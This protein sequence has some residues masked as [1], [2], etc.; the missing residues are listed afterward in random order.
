MQVMYRHIS[1]QPLPPSQL[2][3]HL[4]TAIDA[5]ILTALAKQ[6]A[7]RY[8]SVIDFARAFQQAL[9]DEAMMP[10]VEKET[11]LPPTI[12]A[13]QPSFMPSSF[14]AEIAPITP[15]RTTNP[16]Q[17]AFSAISMVPPPPPAY[18]PPNPAAR[19]NMQKTPWGRVAASVAAVCL[20]I[21]AGVLLYSGYQGHAQQLHAHMTATALAHVTA[22]AHAQATISVNITATVIAGNHY[23]A[24]LP[25][26]G[27]LE[28]AEPLDHASAW[29]EEADK[30]FGGSCAYKDGAYHI[31]QSIAQRFY[32]C[33][34]DYN[35][36]DVA[37]QVDMTIVKGDCG[38][39]TF[40]QSQAQE[41]YFR[42]CQD[43][44]ATLYKYM[45]ASPESA[46]ALLPN[47]PVASVHRG[48][49]QKNMLAIVA[50]GH[51]ISL[52]VNTTQVGNTITDSTFTSG[53]IGF[54]GEA[55]QQATEVAYQNVMLWSV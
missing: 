29:K 6:P 26:S 40:R 33:S 34:S 1:D 52:Y 28:L 44:D 20:L 31:T 15:A 23:P 10:V 43:G 14:S 7:Q 47:A 4:S 5:V 42:V 30:N 35:Y 3:P 21:V 12:A 8:S 2:N 48:L 36:S 18:S 54:S 19:M 11:P 17:R 25:G 13:D 49:N 32:Y 50:Q 9:A 39:V 27:V 53:A 51:T 41:Y 55:Q 22:T 38:G 16:D 24:Y 46:V 45:N 37:I